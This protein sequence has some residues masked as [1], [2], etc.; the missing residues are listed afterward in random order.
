M[1]TEKN[2]EK[3]LNERGY[4]LEWGRYGYFDCVP[5]AVKRDSFNDIRVALGFNT[6]NNIYKT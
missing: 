1:K 3:V 6:F 4:N 2:L 5:F